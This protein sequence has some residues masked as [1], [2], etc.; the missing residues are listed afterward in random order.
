MNNGNRFFLSIFM[1][2]I[3]HIAILMII[4]YS[5]PA[6]PKLYSYSE[7]EL[8][9]VSFVAER[10]R[11]EPE[12]KVVN[13]QTPID[14]NSKNITSPSAIKNAPKL[15][16]PENKGYQL[17]SPRF[18]VSLPTRFTP[19]DDG[20]INVHNDK[21]A[22]TDVPF[23]EPEVKAHNLVE[24]TNL[25]NNR[26]GIYQPGI[27]NGKE[28]PGIDDVKGHYSKFKE[29]Y[30]PP[31]PP[32]PV[33]EIVKEEHYVARKTYVIEGTIGNREVLHKPEDPEISIDR[34]IEIEVKFYVLPN[35]QVKEV[36][37]LIKGDTQLENIAIRYMK[38]WIF[39][40]LSQDVEQ[41]EQWG[42][43]KIK[44]KKISKG[45]LY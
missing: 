17:S 27:E 45:K 15:M 39:V 30:V 35:G 28:G 1:S 12:L 25:F 2:M 10:E 13:K 3:L 4:P 31:P 42:T 43:L 5:A 38:S 20:M 21:D 34:D 23:G 29:K 22:P 18:G 44:F 40:P 14:M 24:D 6:S 8:D 9:R 32:K 33:K 16:I 41:V 26:D 11:K 36:I 37:P 19:T 7:V